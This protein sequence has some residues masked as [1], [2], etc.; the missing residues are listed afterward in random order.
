MSYVYRCFNNIRLLTSVII[1]SV[2]ICSPLLAEEIDIQVLG[3]YKG[4]FQA[5]EVAVRNGY[6]FIAGGGSIEVIKVTKDA[7]IA[8]PVVRVVPLG[9]VKG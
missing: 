7:G 3:T 2:L 9:V 8:R 6:A 1:L 4:S 5:G